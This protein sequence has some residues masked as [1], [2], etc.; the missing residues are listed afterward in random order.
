MFNYCAPKTGVLYTPG[1]VRQLLMKYLAAGTRFSGRF[2]SGDVAVL[3]VTVPRPG[4]IEAPL[5]KGGGL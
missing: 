4:Q 3:V 1:P 5:L 2:R